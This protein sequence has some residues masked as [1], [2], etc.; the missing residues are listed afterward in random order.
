MTWVFGSPTVLGSSVCV[1]DIQ[2]T[3]S[4]GRCLDCLRKLYALDQNVLAGFAGDVIAGFRL[5][6]ALQRF[7]HQHHE[8]LAMSAIFE[9]FPEVARNAFGQLHAMNQS[10]SEVMIAGASSRADALYGSRA[11]VARFLYPD[12]EP[13][14]VPMREWAAIGSGDDVETYRQELQKVSGDE[15][16]AAVGLESSNPGGFGWA[17]TISVIQNV[18]EMPDEPGISKHFHIGVAFAHGFRFAS[19]DRWMYPPDG[20][21]QRIA[22]PPVAQNRREFEALMNQQFGHA[23]GAATATA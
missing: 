21:P 17:L 11:E 23:A 22:M 7:L 2:V 13:E 4:D 19:S 12:F 6:E 18:F 15:A 10:G 9:S 3:L 20:P 8:P 16:M 14:L 5:L 1:A